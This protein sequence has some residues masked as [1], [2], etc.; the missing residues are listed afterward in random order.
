[1]R[2]VFTVAIALW[3]SIAHAQFSVGEE[4]ELDSPVPSPVSADA[5]RE[6]AIALASD[7]R[8]FLAT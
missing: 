2:V 1:V 3:P 8:T 6:H 4:I 7:G 5:N